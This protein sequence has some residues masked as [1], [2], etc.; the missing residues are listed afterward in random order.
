MVTF[1]LNLLSA[2]M[3]RVLYAS[4]KRARDS[5]SGVIVGRKRSVGVV[6]SSKTSPRP[7]WRRILVFNFGMKLARIWSP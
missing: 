2:R 3:Y 6:A 4:G 5:G 7:V 1:V